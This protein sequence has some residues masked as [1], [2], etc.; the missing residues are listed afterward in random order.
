VRSATPVVVRLL[1]E[2]GA[3]V[4]QGF[5]MN[6]VPGLTPLHVVLHTVAHF[7]NSRGGNSRDDTIDMSTSKLENSSYSK[8]RNTGVK[9]WIRTVNLL[10]NS[11]DFPCRSITQL[12]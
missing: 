11:G 2:Y 6:G 1:I 10:L 8:L 4:N 12:L 9:S 3:E 5:Q 7:M